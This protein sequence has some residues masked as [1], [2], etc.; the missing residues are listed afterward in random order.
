MGMSALEYS[1]IY[2]DDP[3]CALYSQSLTGQTWFGFDG[4]FVI[5][6][7]ADNPESRGTLA[8]ERPWTQCPYS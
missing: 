7:I 1:L 4:C 8:L 3:L 5:T 2:R 6:L